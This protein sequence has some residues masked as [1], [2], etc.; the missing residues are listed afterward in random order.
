MPQTRTAT[1]RGRKSA[2]KFKEQ[3]KHGKKHHKNIL[4]CIVL[5]M[6]KKTSIPPGSAKYSMQRLRTSLSIPQRTT[7]GIPGKW[8]SR[9]NKLLTKGISTSSTR[10]KKRLLLRIRLVS[11]YMTLWI[12]TP[13]QA[14]SLK[15]LRMK[16][17]R[18]PSPKTQSRVTM[19]KAAISL[20]T[21]RK[22]SE[23]RLQIWIYHW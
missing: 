23:K 7:R 8:I 3:D 16:T 15:I 9:K 4:C 1:P 11:F 22:K 14:V 21:R 18:P 12:A 2:P 6:V 10:S 20:L 17:R 19:T 5:S 13:P